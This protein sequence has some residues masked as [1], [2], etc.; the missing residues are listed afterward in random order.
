LPE[1][2]PLASNGP[3]AVHT[4][5][6]A[7]SSPA[8][9]VRT[10]L[11]DIKPGDYVAFLSYLP[12]SGDLQNAI[13]GI[14]RAIRTKTRAASTFGVGPRYLH[15]TGQYH[16]GGPTTPLVFLITGD[17]QTQTEIPDA[18]YSFSVLKR[19][20]ALG[21]YETLASHGRRAVRIHVTGDDAA[22]LLVQL[23]DEA[24]A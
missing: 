6:F 13:T 14:R 21:D 16:K 24:L 19:A 2:E 4:R 20:Q 1:T 11:A 15:S 18:G 5:S 7:G 10:A 17:D 3:I 8:D 22:D 23:F 12:A 9:V